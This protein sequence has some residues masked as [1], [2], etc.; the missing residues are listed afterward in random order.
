MVDTTMTDNVEGVDNS[1]RKRF[2]IPLNLC[3][4]H[5]TGKNLFLFWHSAALAAAHLS[6]KLTGKS[7]EDD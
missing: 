7:R 6:G 3:E 5:A 4:N 2:G 1:A